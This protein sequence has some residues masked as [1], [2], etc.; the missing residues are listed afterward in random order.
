MNPEGSSSN[1]AAKADSSVPEPV[2][3]G[4][5]ATTKR[6]RHSK[7]FP[8]IEARHPPSSESKWQRLDLQVNETLQQ[9]FRTEKTLDGEGHEHKFIDGVDPIEGKH[10][11][12]LVRDNGFQNTLEVGLAMGTSALYLCQAIA[13]HGHG[14]KHI[15]IDPNQSSQYRSIG[16]TG[17]N[18][19]GLTSHFELMEAPSYSAL[20]KLLE[21]QQCGK[22]DKFDLIF[23]DGWHTFDY[24]LV[25]FFYADLLLAEH[26]VILL[27]DIR[28]RGPGAVFDYIRKNYRH[29]EYIRDTPCAKTLATFVKVGKDAREWNYH[30]DF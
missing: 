20:P 28:H 21:E 13:D 6:A 30:V 27:D 15:A 25:D 18:R 12:N 24:T 19:A 26:G 23:I 7:P 16:V 14:G 29:Y 22:R 2:V 8:R 10:M 1:D 17:V 11:Y 3:E 9:I 5:E 4:D